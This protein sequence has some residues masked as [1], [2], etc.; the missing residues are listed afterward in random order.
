MGG[1]EDVPNPEHLICLNVLLLRTMLEKV[2]KPEADRAEQEDPDRRRHHFKKVR[3]LKTLNETGADL[4][5][6]EE[7][8]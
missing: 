6:S 2:D 8:P 4:S 3:L 7:N 1:G 5:R